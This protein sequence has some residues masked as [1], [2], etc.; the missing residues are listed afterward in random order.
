MLNVEFEIADLADDRDLDIEEDRG[1][2]VYRIGSHLTPR[3]IAE[4]LTAGAQA[5]LRG[6]H[7]FQEWKGDII[8]ANP[9]PPVDPGSPE[10]LS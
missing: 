4:A 3:Q 6:G 9:E 10:R 1:R 8:T 7:W 5:I 2:V